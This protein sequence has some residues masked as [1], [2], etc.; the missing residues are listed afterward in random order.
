[1]KTQNAE[2]RISR[3]GRL[4]ERIS[5]ATLHSAFAILQCDGFVISFSGKRAF[6]TGGSRGIGRATALLLARAGAAVAVGY[7]N[8]ASDAASTV[9]EIASAGGSAVVI[10][11]DLGERA[12]AEAAVERAFTA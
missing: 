8:R 12:T 4:P 10:P 1:Y 7:R 2:C 9:Q 11:G 3:E 5:I 6:I